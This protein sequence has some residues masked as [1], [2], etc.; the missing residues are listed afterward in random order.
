MS[1]NKVVCMARLTR[2]P[3][4]RSI[5]SGT[6]VCEFGIAFDNGFGD[7]KKTC[8]I[9][10]TAWGK[11]AEFVN[12]YFKKG[13]GIMIDG[14]LE[15]DQWEDKNGGGKRSKHTI[16]AERVTFPLSNKTMAGQTAA[17]GV[18]ATNTTHSSTPDPMDIPF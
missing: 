6:S 18:G 11:S 2:D 14:R 13:D 15:F 17:A 9:T 8:F 1:Y 4:M 12:Q 3:E 10:V 7:N 5:Q 16:T